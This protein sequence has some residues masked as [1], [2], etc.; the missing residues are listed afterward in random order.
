MRL[1]REDGFGLIELITAVFLLNIGILALMGVFSSGSVAV[2]NAA[3]T[4]NGTAVA[5][6]VMEEY[7]GL[8]DC[9]I[10]LNS[11]G[12]NSLGDLGTLQTQYYADTSAYNNV[13]QYPTGSWVVDTTPASADGAI[14]AS[15][16]TLCGHSLAPSDA[17]PRFAH[18]FV[19]G[20][21]GKAYLVF[22][23]I[24]EM[25]P[26]G[27]NPA[28]HLAWTGTWSKQVTVR[29]FDWQDTTKLIARETSV[30]DPHIAGDPAGA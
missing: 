23:Y 16:W 4:A 25:Q 19:T 29:V 18:Q 30:I 22:T 21:D 27:T 28:T 12:S 15:N 13:G 5:D 17:D 9:A 10:F 2:R 11:T 24:V 26:T 8:Y 14:K 6:K 1:R 7:R 3:T 20:P